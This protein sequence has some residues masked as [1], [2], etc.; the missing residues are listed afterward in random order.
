[1]E[2]L[3]SCTDISHRFAHYLFFSSA[4][5]FKL[6]RARQWCF[7]ALLKNP[8]W[9]H[10][11]NRSFWQISGLVQDYS[12]CSALAMESLQSC[13]KPLKWGFWRL[14][15]NSSP[16]SAAYMHQWIGSALVQIMDCRL[17]GAKPLS[18][19]VLGYCQL[20]RVSSGQGKVREIPDL[21]KVREKSGNFGEGQ[22]KKMNVGKS[23]GKVREFTFST[24]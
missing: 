5:V 19:P 18:E 4:V 14:Y 3:Q 24:T 15:I 11:W 10:N 6:C 8:K 20:D 7:H 16:P 13:T 22:G 17:Y 23:Q 9:L 21:A 2:L 1:M 12:N